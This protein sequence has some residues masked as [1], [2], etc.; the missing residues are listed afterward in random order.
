[1]ETIVDLLTSA[2]KFVPDKPL[3]IFEDNSYT[4]DYFEK[5]TNKIANSLKD[6]GVKK[7]DGIALFLP[8]KPIF[9]SCCLAILKIGAMA[10][11]FNYMFKEQ[12]VNRMLKVTGCRT[13]ITT[14][15]GCE[16]LENIID[17]LPGLKDIILVAEDE[18]EKK[19]IDLKNL[20]IYED[21]IRNASSDSIKADINPDD[22]AL[23]M[24]SSGTTGIPKCI[25]ETHKSIVFGGRNHVSMLKYNYLNERLVCP[26]PI[27]NNYG[28]VIQFISILTTV[29]TFIMIE[30]WDTEKVYEAMINYKV[31]RIGGTPTMFV[32]LLKG[33]NKELHC[34][35]KL[36]A[37][38]VAGQKCSVEVLEQFEKTFK[39]KLIDSYGA[40]EVA[41]ATSGPVSGIYKK[42]SAGTTVGNTVVKIMDDNLNELAPN[43][44]GEVVIKSDTAANGY[45]NNPEATKE[46][47][48]SSGWRSGDLGYMDTDGYLYIVDRKK[49]LIITGGANIYPADVEEVLYTHPKVSIVSVVGVPDEQKGELPVAYIICEEGET[50]TEK[51]II[52]FCRDK[53]AVYKAPRIVK[54]VESIPLGPTGKVLKKELKEL[55]AKEFAL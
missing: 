13:I 2:A 27:Y 32:Y 24:H 45:W 18:Q 53:L 39:T 12:E 47:F 31:T 36:D 49:D 11:P 10:A 30:K 22:V 51:E 14:K 1:M 19:S 55:A 52:D 50:A 5:E 40:S 3:I 7:G 33:F 9:C 21:L 37:C 43:E 44:I 16:I 26:L 4:Y 20:I 48:T 23:L 17:D 15:R 54:F 25:M 8:S 28:F 6:L 41:W 35:I 29:G 34:N 46:F 42:G 38:Q